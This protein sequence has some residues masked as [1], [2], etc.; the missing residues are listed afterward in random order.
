MQHKTREEFEEAKN[1]G[2]AFVRLENTEDYKETIGAYILELMQQ[3]MSIDCEH[4]PDP[5]RL[6]EIY[7]MR[8]GER[9]ML[10]ALLEQVKFWRE[11]A[12]M[13]ASEA[14]DIQ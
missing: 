13:D 11:D 10:Y 9:N 3:P 4:I 14:P 6:Q 5:S 8:M 1:K 2:M 12:S 7:W